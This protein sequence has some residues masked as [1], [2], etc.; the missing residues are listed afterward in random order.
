M[1]ARHSGMPE[2]A[3]W[4]SF[5]E[6]EA[7]LDLLTGYRIDGEVVEFGCG[8]GTFTLPCARRTSGG[9]NALDI[10]PE[11]T[12]LVLERAKSAELDN[13]RQRPTLPEAPRANRKRSSDMRCRSS[14]FRSL[15]AEGLSG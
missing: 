12:A 8:Y 9:V 14:A 3:Q 5:F 2:E 6:P 13:V 4:S 11:M 7:A 10:D 15:V 1:K